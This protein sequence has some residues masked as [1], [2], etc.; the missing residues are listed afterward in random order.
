[1]E[2][3]VSKNKIKLLNTV[4]VSQILESFLVVFWILSWLNDYIK[5][6]LFLYYS[7]LLIVIIFNAIFLIVKSSKWFKLVWILVLIASIGA[8]VLMVVSYNL[9]SN[10]QY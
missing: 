2:R 10:L 3:A 1:M 9:S 4:N 6:S 5:D 7:L 8:S